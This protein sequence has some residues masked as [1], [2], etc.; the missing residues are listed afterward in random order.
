[1]IGDYGA[2]VEAAERGGHATMD[3]PGWRAAAL[4]RLGRI[5]EAKAAFLEQIALVKDDWSAQTPASAAN[6]RDWFLDCFPI[7]EQDTR[8]RLAEM[9]DRAVG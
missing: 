5:A 6:V 3:N 4:A 9:L 8:I 1:M 2:A 7:G